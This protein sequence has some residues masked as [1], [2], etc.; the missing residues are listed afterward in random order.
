[1]FTVFY[2]TNGNDSCAATIEADSASA[3]L[4]IAAC[5]LGPDCEIT[6]IE[7]RK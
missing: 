4:T 7:E 2:T 3:A 6:A 1:M 5:E